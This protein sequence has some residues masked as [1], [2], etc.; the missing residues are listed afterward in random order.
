MGGAPSMPSTSAV[1]GVKHNGQRESLGWNSLTAKTKEGT[2]R[3]GR[4][5]QVRDDMHLAHHHQQSSIVC[6]KVQHHPQM[7]E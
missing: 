2:E 1:A 7:E 4:S 5:E 6:T 3:G